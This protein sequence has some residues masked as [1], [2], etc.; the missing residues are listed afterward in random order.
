MLEKIE[1]EGKLL[2]LI[3]RSQFEDPGVSFVT[4]WDNPFQ[5]G[6]LK[7]HQGYKIKP[8]HH[9][10]TTKTISSIQEALH[11]EYGEVKAAFY[12]ADGREIGSAILN[13]GDTI[14]LLSGG[15]GFEILKD[16]K[17]IEIKQGPYYGVDDDKER[18]QAKPRNK[19]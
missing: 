12:E 1:A 6:V 9:K 3:L 13:A 5:L 19:C 8:H 4:S 2:A 10:D 18:F 17:I 14:L 11:I 15:H 16:S 7:H